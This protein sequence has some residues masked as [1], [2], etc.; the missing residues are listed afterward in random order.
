MPARYDF[1]DPRVGL[2]AE[3]RHADIV[4]SARSTF[5]RCRLSFTDARFPRYPALP[6][7]ECPG[8][9]PLPEARAEAADRTDGT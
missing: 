3:C 2:C 4:R 1:V 7:V 6:V 8:F 9:E 5:Y